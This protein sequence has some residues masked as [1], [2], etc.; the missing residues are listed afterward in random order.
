M[1]DGAEKGEPPTSAA[2]SNRPLEN[3]VP[4]NVLPDEEG[5]GQIGVALSWTNRR[6]RD[7]DSDRT[8]S[9]EERDL[10]RLYYTREREKFLWKLR[11]FS[12]TEKIKAFERAPR[13][14]GEA[15]RAGNGDGAVG[16][17]FLKARSELKKA[18]AALEY[19]CREDADWKKHEALTFKWE[20]S[21]EWQAITPEELLPAVEAIRHKIEHYGFWRP[22]E[23]TMKLCFAALHPE[24][25]PDATRVNTEGVAPYKRFLVGLLGQ[26]V[27]NLLLGPDQA[28]PVIFKSYLNVLENAMKAAIG[29]GF[30]SMF[31]VAEARADVLGMH[32]VEWT[33][34]QLDILISAEKFGIRLWVQRVCDI[35]D[36]A[37]AVTLDDSL[38]SGSWRAPRL[39]H[40]QPAGNTHYDQARAWEREDLFRSQEL[41]EGR[42]EQTTVF[43]RLDL[44]ELARAA[45]VQLAKREHPKR[46]F[47][48]RADKVDQALPRSSDPPFGR[49]SAP[50]FWRSLHDRFAVL[51]NE[52]TT[53][54]PR[55]LGD[56]WLR[57]Y[58]DYRNTTEVSGEWSLSESVHENF[59]ER[60]EVEATRAGIALGSLLSGEP[61][62]LWLHHLFTD[63]LQ[64]NSKLLF[65]ATEEGGTI[66]RTCEASAIYCA[67]LE[68]QA[69]IEGRNP[70]KGV[71]SPASDSRPTGPYDPR[72]D[73]V[74]E[75]VI[76]KVQNPHLYT[77]LSTPEA[78]AYFEVQPR[79]IHR[80]TIEGDLRC[81]ARR[82]SITIESILRLEKNRSRKRR[83]R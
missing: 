74:R 65:A 33:R 35:V 5:P 82:G 15:H 57:A 25:N 39:I 73:T 44:G 26:R 75:A 18:S 34:R 63:L 43:L 83:H 30:Q 47:L 60:F 56:R 32:P 28:A 71:Q 6:I 37:N 46:Q 68:K 13:A 19:L 52:E 41:L 58:G 70:P 9:K 31:E 1:T 48:P 21:R 51:A 17:A 2:S 80:W 79:T 50:D 64:H 53:L 66:I 3:S 77:S 55:N 59:R 76:K 10:L 16:E 42:A 40:M 11:V 45:H 8:I 12:E 20:G 54:A 24:L 22:R 36:S 29:E 69:L 7:L 14:D 61:L 78:A 62:T 72:K 27:E 67:R 49:T 81:G 23:S 38:Y 4:K